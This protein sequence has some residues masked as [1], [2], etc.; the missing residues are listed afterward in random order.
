MNSRP[1]KESLYTIIRG[2]EW[3]GLKAESDSEK[4]T[5]LEC[6]IYT[7]GILGLNQFSYLK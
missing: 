5:A 2:R 4:G 7:Q 6:S 1:N 3:W